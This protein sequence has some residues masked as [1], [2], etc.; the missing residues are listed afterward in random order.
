MFVLLF[1]QIPLA[2]YLIHLV[3]FLSPAS[4]RWILACSNQEVILSQIHRVFITCIISVFRLHALFFDIV[5]WPFGLLP[6]VKFF[7][8]YFFFTPCYSRRSTGLGGT[9][10]L[11][12]H[13]EGDTV[14][15]NHEMTTT[16][17]FV[18]VVYVY[19]GFLQLEC[20]SLSCFH[21]LSLQ[22][23]KFKSPHLGVRYVDVYANMH[24]ECM[25]LYDL[26]LFDR[27]FDWCKQLFY[28]FNL[29][30]RGVP[31]TTS[32]SSDQVGRTYSDTIAQLKEKAL[33]NGAGTGSTHW[34]YVWPT[35]VKFHLFLIKV[36]AYKVFEA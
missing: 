27:E 20:E 7:Q 25:G 16:L 3:Y 21:S 34:R 32:A 26:H 2:K 9:L 11:H 29:F 4:W 6:D 30:F 18:V 24:L 1:C 35:G 8:W 14:S 28:L 12:L 5:P 31:E 10:S 36:V 13:D 33:D 17:Q 23:Y 19:P 15:D 22:P